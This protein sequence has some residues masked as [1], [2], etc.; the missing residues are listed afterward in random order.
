MHVLQQDRTSI[1]KN[2]I[3]DI[4][5][6]HS[7]YYFVSYVAGYVHLAYA[8]IHHKLPNKLLLFFLLSSLYSYLYSNSFSYFVYFECFPLFYF[9]ILYFLLFKYVRFAYVFMNQLSIK[10]L[11]IWASCSLPVHHCFIELKILSTKLIF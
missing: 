6:I 7:I 1:I 5:S 11:L 3:W 4:T 10:D 9:I 2:G 8:G